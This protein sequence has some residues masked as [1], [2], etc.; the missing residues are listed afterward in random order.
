[1]ILIRIT[2]TKEYETKLYNTRKNTRKTSGG[3]GEHLKL[4]IPLAATRVAAT[5][6]RRRMKQAFRIPDLSS[7]CYLEALESL[8]HYVSHW[9]RQSLGRRAPHDC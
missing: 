3:G 2:K 7:L 6:P 4:T 9:Q 8:P 1:V 5:V